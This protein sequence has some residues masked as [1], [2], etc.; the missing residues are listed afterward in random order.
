MPT[1]D[2]VTTRES[3]PSQATSPSQLEG[4]T[5]V[6][7]PVEP[8]TDKQGKG[9][10]PQSPATQSKTE[11]G[12]GRAHW[13]Q[14]DEHVIPKNNLW[15]VFPGL[16][17]CVG[18]A[19]LDQTIVSTAL[20]TIAADLDASASSYSWVASAYLLAA[21]AVIPLYGR[22]SDLFGRKPLLFV[23]IFLF[24]LGSGLCAAAQNA[25]WLCI[26]RAVQG[27]GGGG[28]IGMV[29][30]S[31]SDL[32][33]LNRRA[34]FQGLFGAVWG[35]S[36]VI[37]PLIGGVLTDLNS[38]GN[39]TNAGAKL[40]WRWIFLIN[41]PIG[42]IPTVILFF[43]LHLNPVA[44]RPFM[45]AVREFDFVGY[46]GILAAVIIF[47]FGFSHAESQGFNSATSIALIVV[48]GCLFPLPVLWCFW[49][50]KR[51]PHILPIFP[52]R[53]FRTR[54][55]VLILITVII[56][57]FTFFAATY[58]LPVYFQA[59]RGAT[60]LLSGVYMLP[61]ALIGS[62]ISA[63]CGPIIVRIKAWRPVF[64]WGWSISLLGYGLM[65]KITYNSSFGYVLGVTG[66]CGVG[67]GVLF[68]TPL[69]G[70]LSAMPHKDQA[71]TT[72]ALALVRSLSGSVGITICTAIFNSRAAS[73]TKNIPG[74]DAPANPSADL[75]GLQDLQPPSLAH[76]VQYEYGQ[77]LQTIWIILAPLTA[78]GFLLSLG[79]K[80]YSMQRKNVNAEDTKKEND[81][82]KGEKE[83]EETQDRS[84]TP[85]ED[86]E[87]FPSQE[88]EEIA[89]ANAAATAPALANPA[90]GEEQHQTQKGRMS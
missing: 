86:I 89:T 32:V 20:P 36:S 10:D 53:I 81:T 11:D 83:G 73:L 74:Y 67:Y 13:L 84:K 41:L 62:I 63:V 65:S 15:V 34:A 85:A 9:Q 29:Q 77:A 68:L 45:H 70:M 6:T 30:V 54:T 78:V 5:R 64:W 14:K 28:I 56:H 50:E 58:E 4:D 17:L 27:L 16:M 23:A 80:G 1:Q 21:T 12:K 26:C 59:T 31:T 37:G 38:N 57:G 66:A 51:Y 90:F 33:A 43:C 87:K 35:I 19:A 2:T 3:W 48:G 25:T 42:I 39:A 82:E 47:L 18:L 76:E 55:T 52:P 22:L 46:L 75:R 24:L 69:M 49:I 61:Y 7:T 44:K 71:A 72:S 88:E 79:V 60:P 40:G 8:L